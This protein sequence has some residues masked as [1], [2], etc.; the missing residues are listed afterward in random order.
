MRRNLATVIKATLA[1][2]MLFM[3]IAGSAG[4]FLSPKELYICGIILYCLLVAL[5]CCFIY[6]DSSGRKRETKLD[7]V[8]AVLG[9][10]VICTAEHPALRSASLVLLCLILLHYGSKRAIKR[11]AVLLLAVIAAAN[12]A[13]LTLTSGKGHLDMAKRSSGVYCG[14][15]PSGE[16]IL[17][18][19]VTESDSWVRADYYLTKK[20]GILAQRKLF[21]SKDELPS[22]CLFPDEGAVIIDGEEYPITV[23]FIL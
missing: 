16:L 3:S 15:S 20:R 10:L 1:I 5:D 6:F 17:S 4:F 18:V 9:I 11:A 13:G 12:I 8:T 19:S 22:R 2:S 21:L 7:R 23:S 14:E